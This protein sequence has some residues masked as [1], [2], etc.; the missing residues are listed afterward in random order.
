MQPHCY[1][2]DSMNKHFPILPWRVDSPRP[3]AARSVPCQKCLLQ[4][5]RR[6]EP[7]GKFSSMAEPI[8]M[9]GSKFTTAMAVVAPQTGRGAPLFPLV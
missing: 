3:A 8:M 7:D 9:Q 1:V 4:P 5:N 6:T 2:N